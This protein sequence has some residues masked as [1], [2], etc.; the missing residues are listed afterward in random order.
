MNGFLT[1]RKEACLA[2]LL[3]LPFALAACGGETGAE[4]GAEAEEEPGAAEEAAEEGGYRAV[5]VTDGGVIRGTIRFEGAVPP[6]DRIAASEDAETCGEFQEV[7]PLV[8]AAD[9]GLADAV[10][11]LVDIGQGAALATP[12]SPPALDQNG[13]RFSPH[14]LVVAAGAPVGILNSDPIMHN[15]HT[16]TFE[17]RP[18]NRSQPAG[19][20]KIEV[21]FPVPEKVKV[22]CDVH[23]WMNA[24]IIAVDHPYHVVTGADGGFVIEDVPP[25]TYTLEVWHESLGLTS[26]T[27]TVE[28]EG[29]AEAS[30]V[31]TAEG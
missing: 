6:P 5:E 23:N 8:V 13:C 18:V 31:M 1:S 30:I 14:V 21:E 20:K 12:P 11:S 24:W 15:V 17:N 22:R 28:P 9:G 7:Q 16:L 3:V 29:T 10:V 26:E 27:V 25:G 2:L 4:A 19:L